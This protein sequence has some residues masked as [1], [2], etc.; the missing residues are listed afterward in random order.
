MNTYVYVCATRLQRLR[1]QDLKKLSGNAMHLHT[2]LAWQMYVM[3]NIMRKDG[4][5]SL[6]GELRSKACT[7]TMPRHP[8]PHH[9]TP[10]RA[11]PLYS[12]RHL[13]TQRHKTRSHQHFS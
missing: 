13:T 11:T 7:H 12:T 3:S 4:L 9:A 1:G 10:P 8:A 6:A 5:Q 2:V